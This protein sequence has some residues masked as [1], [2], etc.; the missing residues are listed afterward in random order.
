MVYLLLGFFFT[1][2]NFFAIFNEFPILYLYWKTIKISTEF[3]NQIQK[4]IRFALLFLFFPR[5]ILQN[6]SNFRLWFSIFLR[7]LSQMK[8]SFKHLFLQITFII[9]PSYPQCQIFPYN[10][11]QNICVFPFDRLLLFYHR[12]SSR[13]PKFSKKHQNCTFFYKEF[14]INLFKLT[15]RATRKTAT[16]ILFI[17]PWSMTR[18][19]IDEKIF[20]NHLLKSRVI[21][22]F[23]YLGICINEYK[24]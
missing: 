1:L 24:S 8:W 4:N 16:K 6:I 13:Q 5:Y 9:Y 11:R 23:T 2:G 18:Y 19:M 14:F 17:V 3:F 10:T 7:I 22:S 21:A 15:T 12:R 20:S